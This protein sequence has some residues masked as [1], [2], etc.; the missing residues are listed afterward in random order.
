[1][2][3]ATAV[4]TT[5]GAAELRH[6]GSEHRQH[7]GPAPGQPPAA[8][9]ECCWSTP[10]ARSRGPVDARRSSEHPGLADWDI[11][12]VD[13]PRHRSE[14]TSSCFITTPRTTCRHAASDQRSSAATTSPRSARRTPPALVAPMAAA[15]DSDRVDRPHATSTVSAPRSASTRSATRRPGVPSSD[16]AYRTLFPHTSTPW[17]STAPSTSARHTVRTEPGHRVALARTPHP[18]IPGA[19][20]TP[21][22]TDLTPLPHQPLPL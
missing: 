8:N 10:R 21:P 7:R 9:A 20:R 16:S 5:G 13:V 4:R 22:D 18:H 1:M 11:V 3:H 15:V 6:P 12:G 17:P 2:P 14:H 19:P